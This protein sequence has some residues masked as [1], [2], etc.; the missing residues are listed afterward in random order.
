M[1]V[2]CLPLR[3]ARKPTGQLCFFCGV[4]RVFRTRHVCLGRSCLQRDEKLFA[5]LE[6]WLARLEVSMDKMTS[7]KVISPNFSLHSEGSVQHVESQEQRASL[8]M[9]K[10]EVDDSNSQ[11]GWQSQ[12]SDVMNSEE[13][14]ESEKKCL[15]HF[16]PQPKEESAYVWQKPLRRLIESWM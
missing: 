15:P 3:L 14:L 5:R 12:N 6:D 1:G 11:A 16:C 8:V 2:P 7:R 13:D 4:P 10:L 9:E